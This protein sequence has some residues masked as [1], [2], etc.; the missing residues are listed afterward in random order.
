[1]NNLKNKY[2]FVTDVRGRGLLLAIEF[3]SEIS[4]DIVD[5]CMENG[6][7]VNKLKP[8]AIRLIPPLVITNS[9]VDEALDIMEKSFST[10]D[11]K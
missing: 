10:I 2:S 6:M 9:D 1:L 11:N 7:L 8:N 5:A 4:Q 3:N